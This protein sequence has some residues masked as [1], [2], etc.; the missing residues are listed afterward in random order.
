MLPLYRAQQV[1]SERLR[2]ML[3]DDDK[4][5]LKSTAG[6]RRLINPYRGKP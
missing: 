5:F 4:I 3:Y 2:A 6:D 1:G